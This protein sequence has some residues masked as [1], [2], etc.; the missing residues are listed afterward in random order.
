MSA[1]PPRTT[2]LG[3]AATTR[4]AAQE[5]NTMTVTLRPCPVCGMPPRRFPVRGGWNPDTSDEVIACQKG[6]KPHWNSAVVHIRTGDIFGSG[7]R[8]LA[9]AWNTISIAEDSQGVRRVSFDRYPPDVWQVV[10]A[11]S[12]PDGPFM[13][14]SREV[15][16]RRQLPIGAF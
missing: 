1:A 2:W 11:S 13:P 10:Q 14:W 3:Q 16:E 7:W 8:D 9:D 5:V 12:T 15:S 6:C 4:F